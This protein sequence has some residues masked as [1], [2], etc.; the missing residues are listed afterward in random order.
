MTETQV[1][2]LRWVADQGGRVWTCQVRAHAT[3]CA[4]SAKQARARRGAACR[5]LDTLVCRGLLERHL[6]LDDVVEVTAA[7]IQAIGHG[8]PRLHGLLLVI[9]ASGPPLT[10][11]EVEAWGRRMP[12]PPQPPRQREEAAVR[13]AEVLVSLGLARYDGSAY[14]VTAAGRAEIGAV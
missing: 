11:E 2:M 3:A 7:G 1:A 8:L 5:T 6:D 4:L 10:R 14:V 9:L 12:A 13:V